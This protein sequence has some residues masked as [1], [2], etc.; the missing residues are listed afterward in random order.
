MKYMHEYFMFVF[1][2]CKDRY[3][4][5]CVQICEGQRL[6]SALSFYC[7]HFLSNQLPSLSCQQVVGINLSLSHPYSQLYV[8]RYIG[9]HNDAQ[10]LCGC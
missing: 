8:Y 3:M 4:H 9:T 5:V 6:I 7:S 10:F 2:T 1:C